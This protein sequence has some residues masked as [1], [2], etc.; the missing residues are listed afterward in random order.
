MFAFAMEKLISIINH[1]KKGKW[2]YL[3]NA[4]ILLLFS[5][6]FLLENTRQNEKY[7]NFWMLFFAGFVW[8]GIFIYKRV[9][10]AEKERSS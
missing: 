5:G 10:L 1:Y 4:L 3:F 2:M 6:Y 7:S 8:L 9:Q